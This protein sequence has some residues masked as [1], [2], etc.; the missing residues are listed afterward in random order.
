[1]TMHIRFVRNGAENRS[2][3]WPL[4]DPCPVSWGFAP[5]WYGM[6][7]WRSYLLSGFESGGGISDTFDEDVGDPGEEEDG[8]DDGVERG[9]VVAFLDE[10]PVVDDS[11]DGGDVDEAVEALPVFPSHG[12]QDEGWRG[13]GEG[14]EE[15]PG[16]ESDLDEAALEDVVYH[17]RPDDLPLRD[18]FAGMA[19]A[20]AGEGGGDV[21]TG[22][23]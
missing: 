19:G 20:E 16:E 12:A 3:L 18:E 9:G 5:G 15:E 17:A 21:I 14:E 13:D 6:R 23:E 1:M 10:P 22:E 8:E 2:G 4:V 7:L 11:G